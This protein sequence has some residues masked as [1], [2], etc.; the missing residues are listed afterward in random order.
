MNEHIVLTNGTKNPNATR[1]A[2][3][4]NYYEMRNRI[5]SLGS[6]KEILKNND[7][8][9]SIIAY[10][11][12]R[13]FFAAFI[14]L[15]NEGLANHEITSND[16]GVFTSGEVADAIVNMKKTAHQYG[17][18][19]VY[20]AEIW[21]KLNY[22][23]TINDSY[24]YAASFTH[25]EIL[26]AMEGNGNRELTEWSKSSHMPPV[27]GFAAVIY[28]MIE[29]GDIEDAKEF[30][31]RIAYYSKKYSQAHKTQ[32]AKNQ[33]KQQDNDLDNYYRTYQES[34]QKNSSLNSN[35]LNHSHI[36]ESST[37]S[38]IKPKTENTISQ[39]NQTIVQNHQMAQSI[40]NAFNEVANQK[41]E[42]AQNNI[43]EKD[44]SEISLDLEDF[45]KQEQ[46][47]LNAKHFTEEQKAKMIQELYQEFDNYVEENPEHHKT[48]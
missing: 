21:D 6:L 5:K 30:I 37:K 1:G 13:H 7:L 39:T 41:I 38:D 35:K 24:A 16:L 23:A 40:V 31:D 46:T 2:S 43:K 11:G 3:G 34:L 14:D 20:P 48:R 27:G 8:V 47:I 9:K 26:K 25:P 18:R 19:K 42:N 32:L 15:I 4:E 44:S 22:L 17:N 36:K 45:A 10:N 29:R 12:D 28:K 33:T